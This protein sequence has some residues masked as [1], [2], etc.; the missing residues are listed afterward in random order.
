[1]PYTYHRSR[2]A[3]HVRYTRTEGK[4][5]PYVHC[6]GPDDSSPRFT[7]KT[8]AT[9]CGWCYLGAPHTEA[10]HEEKR[11]GRRKNQI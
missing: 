1:M 3:S 5:D 9:E 7:G 4:T 11:R 6:T 8:N 10:A 2:V